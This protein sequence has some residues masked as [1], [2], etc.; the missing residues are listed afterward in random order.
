MNDH[1]LTMN[2][3]DIESI[4]DDLSQ[5]MVRSLKEK[6]KLMLKLIARF[7]RE[8][9][10]L[11]LIEEHN[12]TVTV[13]ESQPEIVEKREIP[14]LLSTAQN[15]VRELKR[16][17]ASK[18]KVINAI[19][20]LKAVR[21]VRE[22]EDLAPIEEHNVTVTVSESQPEIVKKWEIPDLLSTAQNIV[23]ELKHEKA[24][25]EK[26]INAINELKAVEA[27]RTS[28]DPRVLEKSEIMD[29]IKTQSHEKPLDPDSDSDSS[30]DSGSDPLERAALK[31][32]ALKSFNA[33]QEMVVDAVN[34]YKKIKTE[35]LARNGDSDQY[36]LLNNPKYWKEQG[37]YWKEQGEYRKM[38]EI[39]NPDPVQA[40]AQK[41]REL[42]AINAPQVEVKKAV[43]HYVNV[44]ETY[45]NDSAVQRNRELQAANHTVMVLKA[46][47]AP[48]QE[49]ADAMNHYLA[50]KE[51]TDSD[52]ELHDQMHAIVSAACENVRM[53]KAARAPHQQVKDAVMQY[54]EV[55]KKNNIDPKTWNPLSQNLAEVSGQDTEVDQAVQVAA[56]NIR[57]LKAA[58]APQQEIDDAVQC[59]IDTVRD[60]DRHPESESVKT[61]SHNNMVEVVCP[62]KKYNNDDI[63]M[64]NLSEINAK[65]LKHC[66]HYRA[67]VQADEKVKMLKAEKAP[68]E[69]VRE[70][71]EQ[72]ISVCGKND[73]QVHQSDPVIQAAE[74]IIM[75]KSAGAPEQEVKEAV[76]QYIELTEG[77]GSVNQVHPSDPV[78]EAAERIRMLKS[79][80]APEE[81]V[82]EAVIQYLRLTEGLGSENQEKESAN[83]LDPNVQTT[84][85]TTESLRVLE[86]EVKETE[87]QYIP[88]P[89]ESS[90]NEVK[91]FYEACL[92]TTAEQDKQTAAQKIRDLKAAKAPKEQ[93]KVAVEQ[94]VEI[95]N[96]TSNQGNLPVSCG[97]LP[98]QS[99]P[100]NDPQSTGDSQPTSGSQ[101]VNKPD[102][103]QDQEQDRE[104][105]AL[106]RCLHQINDSMGSVIQRVKELKTAGA[107]QQEVKDAVDHFNILWGILEPNIN[108]APVF[109]FMEQMDRI[110]SNTS[111]AS[112]QENKDTGSINHMDRETL[113][114]FL[115]EALSDELNQGFATATQRVLDL[116]DVDPLDQRVVDAENLVKEIRGWIEILHG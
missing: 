98:I 70:A 109:G 34:E 11:A 102:Q 97:N 103:N 56:E 37:E 74:K 53:L 38:Q 60:F 88:I 57:M 41:V 61:S 1:P 84:V 22:S 100:T 106:S 8:S 91:K 68:R 48:R 108:G 29:K 107:S 40:A 65:T 18:E 24:S 93:I 44:K 31:I 49:V 79:S 45:D 32:R 10:D 23:R 72:C 39:A 86:Q 47:G 87:T 35:T 69:Q 14:D 16:E 104:S 5:Y 13:S 105:D 90:H 80:G 17:K 75:L 64:D 27:M 43:D 28:V 95:C 42:K 6:K 81:E 20:E 73:N 62:Y 96:K 89:I 30:S 111:W 36:D 9:E 55:C 66:S 46:I 115:K 99:Q 112:E 12:V 78:A 110:E 101:P 7:V 114:K 71:V 51:K 77:S 67:V 59:Y 54:R 25:K 15:I 52:K 19:N 2:S 82:K 21:F 94:Y 92:A 26:V 76:T 50:I 63:N 113:K 33:P 4:Y 58:G 116:E 83:P 85:Q 3:Q